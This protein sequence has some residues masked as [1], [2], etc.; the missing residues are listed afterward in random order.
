MT[1]RAAVAM[2]EGWLTPT[3]PTARLATFRSAFIAVFDDRGDGSTL[4]IV[5]TPSGAQHDRS[6]GSA[7]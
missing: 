1:E 4:T 6:T 3:L 7:S 2:G 5:V